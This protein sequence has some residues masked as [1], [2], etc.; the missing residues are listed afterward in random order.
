MAGRFAV[1]AAASM[2]IVISAQTAASAAQ[3]VEAERM[4]VPRAAGHVVRD[5]SAS[6]R[7]ALLLVGRGVARAR[8]R[9][10]ANS[11]LGIRVRGDAC[12]GPPR[13]VAAIDGKRVLSQLV[14]GR[15]WRVVTVTGPV[16]AA[17]HRITVRLA[18]PHRSRDCRRR[19]RIDSLVL[20]SV[21]A[22][23]PSQAPA[24]APGPAQ[25]APTRW[26]PAQHTTWQWQLTTPVDQTVDAQMFD[27]DLFDNDASVVAA[28]HARGR[29]VLCYL[30]AGTL[31]P[32][33]PDAGS[34]P[35]A[36]IGNELPDWPG[37]HWLDIRRLDVLG[38]I[39][40]HRL[41][42]CAQKGFDGVEPDN[43][44]AYSNSS[45]FPLTA[46]D[47]LRFNSFL[48]DAAHARGLSIGLKNDL[49]QAAALEPSFDFAIN[50][51]CFQNSE[52]DSLQPFAR[53]GKAV[54]V[55]EYDLSVDSFCPQAQAAG[56]MAMLKR[57]SLD[58]WRQTCW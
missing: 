6:G 44:D 5:R 55:A 7:H 35:A 1:V 23:A 20:T 25:S 4:H 39:L 33:R 42:L 27:I 26:I 50:E 40:E 21:P 29:H 38:P 49:E 19:L 9:V 24:P 30:D 53:A 56:Y 18:N 2:A 47:Q 12:S 36:V 3:R 28:L 8:V 10:R 48:A 32:G 22:A 45:G 13:L 46:A 11:G 31:E 16:D 43:V 41:D 17:R 57:L 34:Y 58:A 15:R 52:C 14:R 51:E 54:F 37:E